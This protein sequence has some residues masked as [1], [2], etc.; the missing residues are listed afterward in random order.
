MLEFIWFWIL[1]TAPYKI[2]ELEDAQV[3]CYKNEE[4]VYVLE[5]SNDAEAK[6]LAELPITI[7]PGGSTNAALCE[8]ERP[9]C[10]TYCHAAR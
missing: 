9:A 7:V 6:L 8:E 10:G 3:Y 4:I 1:T 5:I 2:V